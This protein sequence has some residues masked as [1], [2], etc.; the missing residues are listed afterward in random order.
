MDELKIYRC[1]V[2]CN[3]CNGP[4]LYFVKV[5]ATQSQYD[6]GYHYE[7]AKTAAYNEGYDVFDRTVVFDEYDTA[8]K[9]LLDLFVWD[10]ASIVDIHGS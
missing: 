4:D 2:A 9:A 3:G 8:G 6:Q 5:R 10:S 7:G 1:V